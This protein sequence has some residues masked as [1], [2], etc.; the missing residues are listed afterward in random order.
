[1]SERFKSR[2]F[3]LTVAAGIVTLANDA[4]GLNLPGEAILTLV[5]TVAA[6]V[7]GQ[8]LVDAQ[9]VKSEALP[10]LEQD[11][12]LLEQEP[13]A[14]QVAA[15]HAEVLGV[16]ETLAAQP[17]PRRRAKAAAPPKPSQEAETVTVTVTPVVTG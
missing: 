5:G 6:Y 13:L 16:R 14:A 1:M 9:A 3:W 7:L 15:L 2:K 10:L 12:S 8:S 17:R 4:F 11:L